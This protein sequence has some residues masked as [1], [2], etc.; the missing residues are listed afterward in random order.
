MRQSTARGCGVLAATGS[1][2]VR[3]SSTAPNNPAVLVG[4]PQHGRIAVGGAP[5][6]PQRV[7]VH[8]DAVHVDAARTEAA[9]TE[10]A[11][12][13]ARRVGDRANGT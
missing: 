13:H 12:L 6:G 7:A 8:V 10:A 5:G 4:A 3:R 1:S 11:Q 2:P 9:R